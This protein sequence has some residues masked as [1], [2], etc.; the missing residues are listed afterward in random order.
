MPNLLDNFSG[1]YNYKQRE[2]LNPVSAD[3]VSDYILEQ[4]LIRT[5]YKA[6]EKEGI[7]ELGRATG[8]GP[9]TVS[10]VVETPCNDNGTPEDGS[11]DFFTA[12][13]TVSGANAGAG[14]VLNRGF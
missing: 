7:V 4:R 8:L 2:G 1:L 14:A 13:F 9:V 6:A 11:D 3:S 5:M 10:D 12:T